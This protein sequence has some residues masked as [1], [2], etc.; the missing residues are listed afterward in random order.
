MRLNA[1]WEAFMIPSPA[2][3]ANT[4]PITSAGA[5]PV[6]EWNLSWSLTIGNCPSTPLRILSR[7]CGLSSS[8]NPRIVTNTSISGNSETNP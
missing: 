8:T 5:L 2:S 4:S 1:L 7:S 6:S 3:S